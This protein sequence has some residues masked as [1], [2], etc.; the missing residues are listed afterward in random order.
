MYTLNA[1]IRELRKV[2]G[3]SQ[4][5]FAEKFEIPT[6]TLQ[7][8]EHNRRTPPIYVVG[9]IDK[10][11]ESERQAK[12]NTGNAIL[13]KAKSAKD[14][15]EFYTTYETVENEVA[16]YVSEFKGKTVLCNCDDPFESSFSK[17]FIKNFNTLGL[18]GL[19]CTSYCASR[20]LGTDSSLVDMQGEPLSNDNGYVLVLS[21]VSETITPT[22]TD[23]E[24]HEFLQ[25]QKSVRKLIGDGDFR[26]DE[27]IEY[28]KLADI[29]VTNPPFSLFRELISLVTEYEKQFLV[30]GN[31][32]AITY[33][34]IFPLIQENKAW[35]GYQFGDMAFRVPD[36][37]EP[38]ETRFWIDA[39]G[40]KWRSLGNAMWLTNM[41][42]N[43][44]H[45]RLELTKFYDAEAYPR[46]DEYDAIEVSKVANIPQDYKGVMGVPITFLN[47][48]NPEQF[49]IIGEANHGS[50]NSFDLFKP[51]INGKLKFKR[52]LIRNKLPMGA[53]IN[54]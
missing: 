7:D 30:I 44:R 13:N 27:C 45:E 29:V 28:L 54:G 12:Q 41:D 3:L 26:S 18:K 19:I 11:L 49:E 37:S 6:S 22:S 40:Q 16:H 51:T 9:M 35:I 15:D 42:M 1:Q 2:S 17:Y 21:K 10:L 52:I 39:T 38:R 8:W 31:Q 34:E 50:D 20:V 25:S 36:D 5:T 14:N 33:K 48:Y 4:T 23:K 24:V 46:Y 43:R 47:K 53:M 32:N